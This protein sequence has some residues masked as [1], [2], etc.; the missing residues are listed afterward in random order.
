GMFETRYENFR[1]NVPF[2]MLFFTFV[3]LGVLKWPEL[4]ASWTG[5]VHTREHPRAAR[6]PRGAVT[7]LLVLLVV[8]YDV[9]PVK[10]WLVTQ[11]EYWNE[12][13]IYEF[14][15]LPSF[16]DYRTAANFVDTRAAADDTLITF[17]CREYYNYLDRMDYC[18]VSG[19]Y[20]SGDEMIQTYV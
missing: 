11:R 12:G 4:V 1:Y 16:R 6:W 15:G 3:A 17:D 5:A 7:A 9:N 8:S 14:F 10:S 19:T 13:E 20:R 2:G 18:I